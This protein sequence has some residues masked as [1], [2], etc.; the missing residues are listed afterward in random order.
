MEN[1]SGHI[2]NLISAMANFL[3]MLKCVTFNKN[4]H[5]TGSMFYL[6]LH[7]CVKIKERVIHVERISLQRFLIGNV[8]LLQHLKEKEIVWLTTLAPVDFVSARLHSTNTSRHYPYQTDYRG[9]MVRPSRVVSRA[10][11]KETIRAIVGR[12]FKKA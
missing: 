5:K 12:T 7:L 9:V 3:K 11:E 4:Q 1:Y 6:S 2:K 8:T 10:Q